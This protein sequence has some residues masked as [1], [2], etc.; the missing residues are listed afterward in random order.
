MSPAVHDPSPQAKQSLLSIRDLARDE[1]NALLHLAQRFVAE[2]D[3]PHTKLTTLRGKSTLNMFF[4]N[5]TRTRTSFELAGKMLSAD[6]VNF[7]TSNS[8]VKKG[9]SIRDSIETVTMMG[10]D[11]L[12]V[13]HQSS[14][15]P[16]QIK[17]WTNAAVVNAGD[18]AHQHPTQAL[19]DMLTL[20]QHLATSD[21]SGMHLGIIG[22][23]LHSRVTRSLVDLFTMFGTNVTVVAPPTLLPRDMSHWH[24]AVAHHLDEVLQNFDVIYTI[25]PQQERV[26]EALLP[27]MD[28]YI[29]RYSLNT[30]RLE[31]L[32][33]H[34]VIMDAGPLI[35]GVQMADNVA[36]N[37]RNLMNK[38]VRNGVA[39]RMAVL[40]TVCQGEDF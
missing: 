26:H 32:D 14:G 2:L 27:Y 7:T 36:D 28:E 29:T 9:E 34:V 37:P 39:V 10:F 40:N 11:A 13:R 33:P 30:A 20:R 22:D 17:N 3:K 4:E 12:I 8:S 18:G 19:L 16:W 1:A 35:R 25:R 15:M 6:V 23:I 21:F 38:Q 31:R 5:S 24:V